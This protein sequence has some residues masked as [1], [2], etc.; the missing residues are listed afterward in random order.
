MSFDLGRYDHSATGLVIGGFA[1]WH[2]GHVYLVE[3][4]R[5]YVD[6]L[7]I[8][9]EER[10]AQPIPLD[11]RI[12]WARE[13]FAGSNVIAL[14][15]AGTSSDPE[16]DR[17]ASFL[18]QRLDF[19]FGSDFSGWKLA[20]RLGARFIAVDP[21]RLVV[22]VSSTAIRQDPL[23]HWQYLPRC[24]RPY[25]L[26]RV[27]I[28]GPESTGKTTLT[29][30]L[31]QHFNTVAVPEYARPYLDAQNCELSAEDMPMIARG[32][33]A[34]EDALAREANR[35]LFSDT[36]LITTTI[37]SDW[38]FGSCAEWIRE[39]A[40][41]RSYDLYLLLDVDVPW[42]SDR[43]RYL[44]EERQSFLDRCVKELESRNRPFLK[45]SGDWD[46]RFNKAVEAV[47]RLLAQLGS[48]VA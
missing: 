5:N 31:A 16:S 2:A 46:A 30:R 24:V 18:P 21:E 10:A 7:T 22:P 3:F 47:E 32:H 37:W 36:D 39:A 27:C 43:Q 6:N 28:F 40:D 42:V 20:E 35:V 23:A 8:V 4:A 26:R 34:S 14:S 48:P 29:N 12:S 1:P 11:V 9:V 15:D 41:R 17:L 45:L 19:V 44:P 38:L 33:M 13:L 25:Y